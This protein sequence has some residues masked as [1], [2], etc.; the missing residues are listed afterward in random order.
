MFSFVYFVKKPVEASVLVSLP[1]FGIKILN[2][3][4]SYLE[5]KIKEKDDAY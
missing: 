4:F 3:T 1:D 2:I 5:E